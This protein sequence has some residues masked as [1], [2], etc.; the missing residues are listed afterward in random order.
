MGKEIRRVPPNWEHP[1]GEEYGEAR[2]IPLHDGMYY[3]FKAQAWL[4]N[5]ELWMSGLHPNQSDEK[6]YFNYEPPPLREEYTNVKPEECTW[7]QVYETSSEG[8]PL[9]PPFETKEELI[10]YLVEHGDRIHRGGY[11]RESVTAFVEESKP[12]PSFFVIEGGKIVDGIE[13]IIFNN[14]KKW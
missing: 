2:F 8:T 12:V 7:Y 1:K 5:N 6:Y 3:E 11:S 10:N 4:E 14:P 9:T 13:W